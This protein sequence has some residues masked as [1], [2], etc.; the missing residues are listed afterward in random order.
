[1]HYYSFF[2]NFFNKPILILREKGIKILDLKYEKE[3]LYF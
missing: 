2:K 3:N 1:M